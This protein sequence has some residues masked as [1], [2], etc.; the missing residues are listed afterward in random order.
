MFTAAV[1]TIVKIWKGTQMSRDGWM[2]TEN[3]VNAF[4]GI[5]L[6][7]YLAFKKEQYS[8]IQNSMNEA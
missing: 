1:F 8:N 4:N 7:Y 6:D 3:T 5:V 2:D